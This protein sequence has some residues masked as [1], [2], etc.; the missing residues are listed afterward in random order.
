VNLPPVPLKVLV[1]CSTRADA[2]AEQRAMARVL[3]ERGLA[4]RYLVSIRPVRW[5]RSRYRTRY[6]VV[7]VGCEEPGG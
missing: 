3:R 4:S 2:V 5:R 6:E 7:V 1:S